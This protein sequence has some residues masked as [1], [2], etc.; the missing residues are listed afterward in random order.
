MPQNKLVKVIIESG[1]L[2][3]EEIIQ[4]CEIYAKTGVDFLKTSTGYAEKGATYGSGATDAGPSAVY[5]KN[6]S[7]RGHSYL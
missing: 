1:I 4:C 3:N 6:K 5:Y 7:L 2:T